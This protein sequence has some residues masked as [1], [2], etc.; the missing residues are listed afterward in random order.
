MLHDA[1]FQYQYFM[2]E[3]Q[4]EGQTAIQFERLLG[5]TTSHIDTHFLHVPRDGAP[6]RFLPVKD[7]AEL[8]ARAEEIALVARARGMVKGSDRPSSDSPPLR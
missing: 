2:V 6:S 4:V 3:K 8:E 5:E 1:R 7:F